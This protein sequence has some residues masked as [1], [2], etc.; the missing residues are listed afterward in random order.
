LK[1]QGSQIGEGLADGAAPE[2]KKVVEQVIAKAGAEARQVATEALGT[3][4]EQAEQIIKRARTEAQGAAQDARQEA[5]QIVKKIRG[6]AQ[7]AAQDV[8]Q[9]AEALLSSTR[10]ELEMTLK[11]A[12]TRFRKTAADAEAHAKSLAETS[13]R[14]VGLRAALAALSVAMVA[15]IGPFAAN[16][17][18]YVDVGYRVWSW[19]AVVAPSA[20]LTWEFLLPGWRDQQLRP[21]TILFFVLAACAVAFY[22]NG[23]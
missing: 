10:T 3:V 22:L 15:T 16:P 9:V 1:R 5:E 7:G 2:A 4:R 13:Y 21:Y 11:D 20:F 14:K 19:T 12:E 6:E 8:R 18:P 17:P 23:S